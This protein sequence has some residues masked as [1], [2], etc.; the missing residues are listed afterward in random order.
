VDA[1]YCKH[2]H[3]VYCNKCSAVYCEDCGACWGFLSM[4]SIHEIPWEE[5]PIHTHIPLHS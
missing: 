4:Y 5:N 2:E 3:L 1:N